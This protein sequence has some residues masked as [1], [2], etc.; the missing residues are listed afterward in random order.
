VEVAFGSAILLFLIPQVPKEFC[1]DW[2]V[3]GIVVIGKCKNLQDLGI[4]HQRFEYLDQFFKSLVRSMMV[5]SH[6]VVCF[7]IRFCG[8][9]ATERKQNRR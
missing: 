8:L 9:Q 7:S 1:R 2:P 3:P 5:L 6:V 4:A